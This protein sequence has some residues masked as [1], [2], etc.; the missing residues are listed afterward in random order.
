MSAKKWIVVLVLLG[1]LVFFVPFVP[2]TQASGQFLGAHYQRTADVSPTYYL[3]GCGSYVNAQVS[4]GLASGYSGL[5]Q[6]S[7]GYSFTCNFNTQ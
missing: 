3:F 5:Y 2:Q 6:L 7:K 4:A 1:I